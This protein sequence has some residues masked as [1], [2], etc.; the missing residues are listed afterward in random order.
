M[1]LTATD[2]DLL[3]D[4]TRRK[5]IIASIATIGSLS[6]YLHPRQLTR[7]RGI[8]PDSRA[9]AEYR[10][11]DTAD[12]ILR[13]ITG[14]TQVSSIDMSDY[15]G[16]SI[17]HDMNLPLWNSR[18]DLAGKFDLVIDGGTLEHVFNFPV[19]VQNLMFLVRQ[20]GHILAANPANN[21]C[22]HG[23]YQFTPELM[24]RIYAPANGFRVHHVI[25]TQSRHMSVE[26][27]TRPRS[28]RVVD[29]ASLGR[30]I[31]LRNRWPVMIRTLAERIGDEPVAGLDVQ[32]SDY[33][34]AWSGSGQPASRKGPKAWLRK[35]FRLLPMTTQSRLADILMRNTLSN[36]HAMRR[37]RGDIC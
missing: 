4:L 32:Q 30:R 16:S 27:D 22:G 6:L 28:F 29:P 18:P 12:A 24:H 23:F 11:G 37:W 33:V 26:M 7:L 9:L 34:M 35:I 36:P 15:Q 8:I 13:E 2:I 21:L 14:A 20:G 31:L 25:L 3:L 17:V 1:G 10:W 5:R 19:A